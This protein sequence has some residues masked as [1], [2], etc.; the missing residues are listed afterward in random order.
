MKS[1]IVEVTF[2]KLAEALKLP[3]GHTITALRAP[4]LFSDTV[5]IRIE[6]PLLPNAETGQ[7]L[8]TVELDELIKPKKRDKK[9]NDK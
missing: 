9:N 4:G 6:G 8:E 2:E 5:R 1:G 7:R 3:E